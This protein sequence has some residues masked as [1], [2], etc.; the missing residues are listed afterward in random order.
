MSKAAADK[1]EKRSK[2]AAKYGFDA[3]AV[4]PDNPDPV[5]SAIGRMVD[6]ISI[7]DE[8]IASLCTEVCKLGG[9]VCDKALPE[10]DL[11]DDFK[12]A[13]QAAAKQREAGM[14]G[15]DPKI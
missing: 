11:E 3:Y 13:E 5:A 9:D 14:A 4:S 10:I 6:H 12:A 1:H 2:I 8:K 15:F 7:M